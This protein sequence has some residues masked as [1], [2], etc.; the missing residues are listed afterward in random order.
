[1]TPGAIAALIAEERLP[2]DYAEAVERCWRPLAARIA[3][4]AAAARRGVVVAISGAQGTGKTT[5][6]RFLEGLLAGEHGLRT[7]TLSLDDVYLA[8][9]DRLELARS[10]HPLLATRGV[11][12]THDVALAHAIIDALT[13]TATGAVRMPRFD[14]ARDDRLPAADWPLVAAPV[15]VLLFE[16]WCI[17]A[18]P[19]TPAA[20]AEPVNALEAAEDADGRWRTWVNG[21][22][23]SD[24]QRLFARA[25]LTI[26][27]RP[28][29]FDAVLGWRQL[30]GDKLRTRTGHGM[31][32]VEVAR[33]V[34]HY[35]RVTQ[36]LL[37]TLPEIA[38]IVVDIGSDHRVGAVTVKGGP[39]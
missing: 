14:K 25:D 1:M 11:P 27:L 35:Q 9:A 10:V 5:L 15:D 18:T 32:P 12:G 30:Q 13:G 31:A 38:D 33:F 28:P 21:A 24:Y 34:E 3:G 22:L 7:A 39:P 17:G 16:G 2:D 20:L 19:Q 37:R 8:K 23:A 29:G 6:C 36:H 26:L 4:D